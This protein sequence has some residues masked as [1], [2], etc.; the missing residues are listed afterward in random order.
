VAE[1]VEFVVFKVSFE[2]N[3]GSKEGKLLQS[4]KSKRR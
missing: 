3:E 1:K 4:M 2:I